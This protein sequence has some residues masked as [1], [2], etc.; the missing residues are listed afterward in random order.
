MIRT[1]SS[2]LR[3]FCYYDSAGRLASGTSPEVLELLLVVGATPD[4]DDAAD[5][6]VYLNRADACGRARFNGSTLIDLSSKLAY[7]SSLMTCKGSRTPV[8]FES[9]AVL[10]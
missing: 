9:P 1:G 10:F 2:V 4:L 8:G 7:T 6:Y 3:F 5:P